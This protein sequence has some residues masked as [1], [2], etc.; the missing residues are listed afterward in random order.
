MPKILVLSRTAE[1]ILL[2]GKQ[3][4]EVVYSCSPGFRLSTETGLG[5][6]F[7]QQGGWMGVHPY[8]EEDPDASS[9]SSKAAAV[10]TD[11]CGDYHE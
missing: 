4:H 6:M 1:N 10:E 5:H 3:Y 8:C 11:G 7:C 9:S 2:P